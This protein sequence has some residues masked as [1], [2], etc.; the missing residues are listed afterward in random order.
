MKTGASSGDITYT[1]ATSKE[2]LLA[3]TRLHHDVYLQMGYISKAFPDRIIPSQHDGAT[4]YI[5]A[6]NSAHD[7]VGTIRLNIGSPFTTFKIWDRNLY[8]SCEML[9]KE[10]LAGKSFEIGAL[11]VKKEY[12]A[13]KIS[14]GLYKASYQVALALNLTYGVI[15]MDCRALRSIEM[16]GWHVVKIGDPI[17]YYGS[18]T[19]PGVMPVKIQS[20]CI[21]FKNRSYQQY[22]CA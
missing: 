10:V 17:N 5:V 20:E 2:L 13:Q 19:V 3:A 6:L 21:S 15:S 22:L 12:S 14:W 16:L 18:L 7:V 11:A 9:I 1:V 4:V 8:P